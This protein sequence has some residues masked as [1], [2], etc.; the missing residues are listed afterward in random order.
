VDVSDSDDFIQKIKP[1]KKRRNLSADNSLLT[2]QAS[3]ALITDIETNNLQIESRKSSKTID[4]YIEKNILA[5]RTVK[6][7]N[8]GN[9]IIW[10]YICIC[11][12]INHSIEYNTSH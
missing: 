11:V 3:G 2:P 6:N 1:I 12:Y 10:V 9:L 5:I 7:I 4:K 8:I